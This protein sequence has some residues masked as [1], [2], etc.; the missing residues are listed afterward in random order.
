MKRYLVTLL[1]LVSTNILAQGVIAQGKL[2]NATVAL[3]DIPC[4]IPKTYIVY[5]YQADGK[6]TAGCW[7]SDESRVVVSLPYESLRT[8]SHGFF[9]QRELR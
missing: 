7:A 2:K 1:L 4:D 3:T 5:V 8:Y 9:N 6:T